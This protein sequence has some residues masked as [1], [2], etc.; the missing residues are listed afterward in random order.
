MRLKRLTIDEG[1]VTFRKRLIHARPGLLKFETQV[2][3]TA[4]RSNRAVGT[5]RVTRKNSDFY[6]IFGVDNRNTT[7]ISAKP[8]LYNL[9]IQTYSSAC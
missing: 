3:S 5:V 7:H 2:P 6:S 8:L 4:D 1:I 9:I